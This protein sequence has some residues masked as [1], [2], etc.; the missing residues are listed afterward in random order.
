MKTTYSFPHTVE[1]TSPYSASK[2][3]PDANQEADVEHAEPE[4]AQRFRALMAKRQGLTVAPE[5]NASQNNPQ[6]R[7]T[8]T[9]KRSWGVRLT[10]P[11]APPS[12]PSTTPQAAS[13]QS[14]SLGAPAASAQRTIS[15]APAGAASSTISGSARGSTAVG[16]TSRAHSRTGAAVGPPAARAHRSPESETD[17]DASN[18][19]R[20][21]AVTHLVT[22]WAAKHGRIDREALPE[23]T[24]TGATGPNDEIETVVSIRIDHVFPETLLTLTISEPAISLRFQSA[25]AESRALLSDQRD[26]LASRVTNRTGRA[27]QVEIGSDVR[28]AL[29]DG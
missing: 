8:A 22:Q 11:E 1:V 20:A 28:P 4:A 7:D 24:G 18:N 19:A 25:S 16:S 9:D 3:S 14:R 10:L 2:A 26:A 23:H 15:D 6:D 17:E 12:K 21:E 29:P 5:T 13:S 27:T